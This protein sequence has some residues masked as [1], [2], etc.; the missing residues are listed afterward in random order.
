MDSAQMTGRTSFALYP[1]TAGPGKA[2]RYFREKVDQA[3]VE[4]ARAVWPGRCL[5]SR[6]AME[7]VENPPS[8]PDYR[9]T[10]TWATLC[11]PIRAISTFLSLTCDG[12]RFERAATAASSHP[13]HRP[14]C[15]ATH[16]NGRSI[17]SVWRSWVQLLPGY[18]AGP[19]SPPNG[20]DDGLWK[21]GN[22]LRASARTSDTRSLGRFGVQARL[23]EMTVPLSIS[24]TT[25]SEPHGSI[26]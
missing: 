16:P 22:A 18:A 14:L 25:R 12:G 11:L 1:K 7:A 13:L 2:V 24:V 20:T 15:L 4:A 26:S 19:V 5:P 8:F 9:H 17:L 3:V 10:S 21:S 6:T 23:A